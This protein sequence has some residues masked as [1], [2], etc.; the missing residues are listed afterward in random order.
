MT[1]EDV[2]WHGNPGGRV[3]SYEDSIHWRARAEEIRTLADEMS[4]GISKHVMHRIAED[5]DRFAQIVEERP[6]RFL[7]TGSD[8]PAEVRRFTPC[9]DSVSAPPG[10]NDLELPSFLKR[11]P[12]TAAELEASS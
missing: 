4:D 2:R 3:M 1:L 8:L 11:G 7:P 9:R 12:A 5:Y 6:N 10:T